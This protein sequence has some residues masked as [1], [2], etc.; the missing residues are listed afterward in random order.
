MIGWQP[1]SFSRPRAWNVVAIRPGRFVEATDAESTAGLRDRCL[2]PLGFALTARRSEPV[3]LHVDDVLDV[4][5]GL[6]IRIGKS[7]T[8]QDAVGVDVAI[9]YGSR[10]DTCPVRAVRA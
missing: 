2:L 6:L 5:E 8:D 9:P 3:G 7:K 4:E 1:R 10:P